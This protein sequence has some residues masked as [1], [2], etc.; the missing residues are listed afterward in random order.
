MRAEFMDP[1]NEV[2]VEAVAQKSPFAAYIDVAI[3]AHLREYI[4]ANTEI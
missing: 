4:R 2:W 1:H 3:F